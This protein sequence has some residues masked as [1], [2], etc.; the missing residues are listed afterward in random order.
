MALN[1]WHHFFTA[2]FLAK[3][4]R[5]ISQAAKVIKTTKIIIRPATV[6]YSQTPFRISGLTFYA[7]YENLG[8]K[9]WQDYGAH[10]DMALYF[11]YHYIIAQF[12]VKELRHFCRWRLL[13]SM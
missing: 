8:Q 1:F 12:L 3:E 5:H 2:Q 11:C 6:P 7:E 13:T 4:Q 10:R 9:G